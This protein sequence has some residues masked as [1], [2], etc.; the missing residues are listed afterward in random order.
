MAQYKVQDAAGNVRVIEGPDG[1][2][3]EE[4]SA[5]AER[6]FGPSAPPREPV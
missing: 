4:I 1:A 6:L 5:Q 2:S 3:D